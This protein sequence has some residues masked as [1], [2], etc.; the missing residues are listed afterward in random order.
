MDEILVR[1]ED[2]DA[3]AQSLDS[4]TSL[5]APDLVRSIVA[6]IQST[7]GDDETAGVIV[8]VESV[9]DTFEDSFAAA[10]AAPAGKHINVT[11]A[12]IHR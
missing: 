4:G 12:K 11:V 5:P 7:L 10:E 9:P 8:E 1:R 3:L 6:A 2:I